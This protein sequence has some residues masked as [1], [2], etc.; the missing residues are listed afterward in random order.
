MPYLSIVIP[1]KN[2]EKN[3]PNLLE[4]IKSQA[5]QDLEV[6]VADAYSEDRT[7]DIAKDFG[8]KVVDGGLPG[9]GRNRGAAA[10]EGQVLLFLDA[11]VVLSDQNFLEANLQ[12]MK[13]RGV[14]VG[15]TLVKPISDSYV[16]KAMHEVY[17]AFAIGVERVKPH[18]PGFCIFIK[19]HVHDDIGGFDEEV[20]FAEDHEYVQRAV[21]E[22]Y[23]FRVL[24]SAPISVSV[25]RLDK[26][27]RM[28]IA[29]KYV[30]AELHMITK[31]PFKE[32]PYEYE[33][34]GETHQT[35]VTNDQLPI[36][37]SAQKS[38]EQD[39]NS[40]F[41]VQSSAGEDKVCGKDENCCYNDDNNQ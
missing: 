18:A 33:M 14:C 10:A 30:M 13:D 5:F 21:K 40:E 8:A 6:V 37:N 23:R 9:P 29:F 7:R 12:E 26:D 32:M 27:G 22:G 15:T 28:G 19:K 38:D 24:R 2:E 16:D 1:T 25:R 36:T 20:V 4:S 11:D 17:N 41:G 31:G 35:R 39:Q 3:L 34:G